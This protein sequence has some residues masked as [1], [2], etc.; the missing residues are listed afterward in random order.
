MYFPQKLNRKKVTHKNEESFFHSKRMSHFAHSLLCFIFLRVCVC[1]SLTFL[2]KWYS[3][4]TFVRTNIQ[5]NFYSNS[6]N[7]QSCLNHLFEASFWVR[8]VSKLQCIKRINY[9]YRIINSHFILIF[10]V[11]FLLWRFLVTFRRRIISQ[12]L[13]FRC[14]IFML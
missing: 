14:R 13:F 8:R 1:V 6:F 11:W 10:C 7:C 12:F 9:L 4:Y 3:R 2:R 5:F